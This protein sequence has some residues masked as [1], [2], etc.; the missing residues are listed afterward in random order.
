MRAKLALLLMLKPVIAWLGAHDKTLAAELEALDQEATAKLKSRDEDALFRAVGQA[1]SFWAQMEE[2]LVPI[3]GM[4]LRTEFEMAGL[5]M[6]SIINF[7]VRLTIITDLFSMS[8]HYSSLKPRWT[9]IF[10]K[11]RKMQDT[12]DRLAHH[13][14]YSS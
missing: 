8:N 7:C 4:L 14:I 6:Y 3:A 9:K 5:V 12:R 1:L 13:T 2:N 10:E 11:L